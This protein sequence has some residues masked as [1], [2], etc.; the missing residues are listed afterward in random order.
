MA[1]DLSARLQALVDALPLPGDLF[2]DG[3]DPPREASL[4]D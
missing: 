1:S 2:T 3:G 4:D